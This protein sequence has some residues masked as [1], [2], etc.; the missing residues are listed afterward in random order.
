MQT[1]N[2][3]ILHVLTGKEQDVTAAALRLNDVDAFVPMEV[4]LERVD[5]EW[6]SVPRILFPGYVFVRTERLDARRYYQFKRIPGV[7]RLLGL[8]DGDIPRCVPSEEIELLFGPDGYCMVGISTGTRQPS[9]KIKIT[10][11]PL[12]SLQDRIVKVDTRQCRATV[13]LPLLGRPHM[14][15]MALRVEPTSSPTEAEAE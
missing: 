11:G 4:I 9:G 10:G 8:N 1:D 14:V 6:T 12:M 15:V 13:E 7:L 3:Y 5:N 2:W